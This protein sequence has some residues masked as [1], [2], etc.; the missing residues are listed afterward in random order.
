MSGRNLVPA[1]RLMLTGDAAEDARRR[2]IWR[3]AYAG[4]TE[5]LQARDHELANLRH[6]R[7]VADDAIALERAF[8]WRH[9]RER[10]AAVGIR[11]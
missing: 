6:R 9:T 1:P 8:A 4:S 11:L 3:R 10:L 5:P 2:T 7:D